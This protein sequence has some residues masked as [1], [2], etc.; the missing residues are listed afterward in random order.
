MAMVMYSYWLRNVAIP[1]VGIWYSY[2]LRSM[3]ATG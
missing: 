1:R 2:Q 3:Q